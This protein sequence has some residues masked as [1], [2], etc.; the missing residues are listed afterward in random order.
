MLAVEKLET[1]IEVELVLT[2]AKLKGAGV[3]VHGEILQ[4]HG[5]LG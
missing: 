5:T 3:S 1:Q 2:A 4:L